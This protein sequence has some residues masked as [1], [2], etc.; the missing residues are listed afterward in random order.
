MK[1][2]ISVCSFRE[3]PEQ[4]RRWK[5]THLLSLVDTGDFRAPRS[6]AWTRLPCEDIEVMS[7]PR[8]P[9]SDVA[10]VI[11][12]LGAAMPDGGRLLI[13]CEAGV[14]RSGATA[15]MLLAQ[16]LGA[17]AAAEALA[18]IRPMAYPNALM[19]HHADVLLGLGGALLAT[20]PEIRRRADARF[21][22]GLGG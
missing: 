16:E 17:S 22:I 3:L 6:V 5:A 10:Q 4:V 1:Y 7:N 11:L 18:T 19:V 14:S 12:A 8:A 21:V 15:L 13:H 20:L 9:S 2:E